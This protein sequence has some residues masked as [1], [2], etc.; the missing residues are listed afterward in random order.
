MRFANVEMVVALRAG[1]G[2]RFELIAVDSVVGE[3]A[4]REGD[5]IEARDSKLA[6]AL[7][8]LSRTVAGRRSFSL[9]RSRCW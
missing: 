1:D 3:F 2:N 7:N 9:R 6:A 5:Q 8:V 4:L